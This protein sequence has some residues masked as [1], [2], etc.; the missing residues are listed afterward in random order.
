MKLKAL[1]PILETKDIPGTIR[2][3]TGVLGFTQR[4]EFKNGETIAWCDLVRD[5][6]SIMF[7]LPN[8]HMNYGTVMLSGSLYINVEDVDALWNSLKDTCEVVYPLEN[9]IYKMREFAIKDNNG[10]VLNFAEPVRE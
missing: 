9:F 3:Y 4:G 1:A 5:N 10:Y 2:F 8:E 6:V 7:S